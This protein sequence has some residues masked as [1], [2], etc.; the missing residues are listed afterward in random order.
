MKSTENF[1]I[2][3]FNK[4]KMK[5]NL[6]YPIYLKWKDALRNEE[7]L[8]RESAD[9]IAHAM[10]NWAL[11]NGVKYFAHW[12]FPLNGLT[13]KK[14]EAFIDRTADGEPI[15]RFSGKE[16]LKGE[17]DASSFPS[18]GM[19]STFEARGYT[20]W[21]LSSNS[22]I[23]GDV[24]YIPTIFMSYTGEKLDKRGPLLDSVE[25]LSKIGTKVVNLYNLGEHV[26]RLR[27][28]VGLEQEFFLVDKELYDRRAD[29]VNV[30]RTILGAKSPKS[31]EFDDH[32]FG[33]I[34]K[35]VE[36]F[37]KSVNEKLWN[38]GIY[39]KAEHNEVA[40]LQFEIAIL[41]ENV[42]VSIDNNQLIMGLLKETALEHGM[43]CLLH[44]KPFKGVNGSG[45]HNNYSIATNSGIN[46]F[47]P[48]DDPYNNNIFLIFVA[49]LI[50]A[51]DRYQSLL[52]YF[53][54]SPSNDYR[55]G[56]DEAPP[57]I[58]SIFLGEDLEELFKS[59][60]DDVEYSKSSKNLVDAYNLKDVPRD[61]S[62]RN[63]T[64]TFA[65]TGNKFEFR[66]LGSSKCAADV[67]VVLNAAIA[68]SLRGIYEELKD[69]KGE[70]ELREKTLK[71]V[72]DI[73]KKHDRIIASGDN[74]SKEWQDKAIASGLKNH[75]NYL[76]ALEAVSEM[77]LK[78]IFI[79]E[80]IF[81]ENELRAIFDI[82]YE[83]IINYHSLEIR[84][85]LSMI[86]KDIVPS[87]ISEL[88][89]LSEILKFREN[90]SISKIYDRI[91]NG[92]EK[93]LNSYDELEDEY[94]HL[95][96]IEDIKKEAKYLQEKLTITQSKIRDISDELESLIS[97]KNF[98][99]PTYEDMFNSL[100]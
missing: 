51:T 36:N 42:N 59:I 10:K 5:E 40:P 24:L 98:Q 3:S 99:I 11:E 65:F 87:C 96:K 48:G 15:N 7:D 22:F 89:D 80:N 1:G 58:I 71:V 68:E 41:F 9:A 67:N 31:Q 79:N 92:V 66:M 45:K 26:Y 60:R 72:R 53:S 76:E 86:K 27:V 37:Y 97:R 64:A 74:Y 84:I 90:K 81:T 49:A 25:V 29:L 13:A 28:K 88:K 30:G 18:G 57:S 63:R 61:S 16:L 75:K 95:Y 4:Q 34:P 23:I 56:G 6:P 50:E 38:L 91:N 52:R 73:L 69:A 85:L 32:Y 12:F 35:R 8:D 46:C 94:N 54:S 93:L 17:P 100:D 19:R 43:V 20:Y 70:K 47:E 62:D 33:Q 78:N 82:S 2:K 77:D 44:E 14:L 83:E 39:A 55:L 21:D